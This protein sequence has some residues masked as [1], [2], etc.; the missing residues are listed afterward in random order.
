MAKEEKY[1]HNDVS[2]LTTKA[3][4]FKEI[5]LVV[6]TRVVRD[7]LKEVKESTSLPHAP[8]AQFAFTDLYGQEVP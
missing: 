2:Q 1:T 7:S 5:I 3:D 8:Q 4:I 6:F